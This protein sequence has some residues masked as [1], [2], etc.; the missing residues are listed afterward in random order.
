MNAAFALV[1]GIGVAGGV[2]SVVRYLVVAALPVAPERFPVGVLLAN[3]LGSLGLG[4]AWGYGA[5]VPSFS[6]LVV[7]AGLFGGFTTFSTWAADTDLLR[8]QSPGLAA[9]NLAVTAF[10][11]LIALVAGSFLGQILAG[12]A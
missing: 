11:C 7:S 1:L 2:G 10:G 3:L 9:T 6:Y 4:L 12:V 8:R 5:G